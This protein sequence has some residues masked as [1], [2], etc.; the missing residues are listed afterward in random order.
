MLW[1]KAF[2]YSFT[3]QLMMTESFATAFYSGYSVYFFTFHT[4]ILVVRNIT[5]GTT[6]Y[7]HKK[8]RTHQQQSNFFHNASIF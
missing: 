6:A 2:H 4:C 1:I 5:A 3:K 7:Q 8:H